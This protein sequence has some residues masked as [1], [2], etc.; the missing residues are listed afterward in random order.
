MHTAGIREVKPY[1]AEQV[2]EAY[3]SA[4]DTLALIVQS[5][6]GRALAVPFQQTV[7]LQGELLD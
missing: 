6:K 4:G 7:T 1:G 5:R 2:R 3:L